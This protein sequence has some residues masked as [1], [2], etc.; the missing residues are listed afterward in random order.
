MR[1]AL[2]LVELQSWSVSM[3]ALD[4]MEKAAEI[5]L[6]QVEANDLYGTCLKIAG[7]SARVRTAVAAGVATAQ[8]MKVPCVVRVIDAPEPRAETAWKAPA[9]FSPL[10]ESSLVYVPRQQ[11]MEKTMS[12]PTPFAIGMIETQGFTAVFEAIDTACKTANVEVI[13]REKLGGGYITVLVKGD[14]A[15]VTAA[16]AAGKEKVAELGKLIAAHVIAH[17]SPSVL[18]LLPKT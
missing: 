1:R 7:P 6:I 9:E 15:A 8:A 13:G 16:V 4:R 5:E 18:A 11:K 3:V 10:I 12:A 14:V 2:G 17:P